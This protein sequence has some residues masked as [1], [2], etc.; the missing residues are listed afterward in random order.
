VNV[1]RNIEDAGQL[2]YSKKPTANNQSA[3]GVY[4]NCKIKTKPGAMVQKDRGGAKPKT[5]G[6]GARGLHI[7]PAAVGVLPGQSSDLASDT[8]REGEGGLRG[9]AAPGGEEKGKSHRERERY[10]RSFEAG[11]GV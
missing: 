1:P 7:L 11:T 5:K 10:D 4:W 9:E 8:S 6:V 3:S 2:Y